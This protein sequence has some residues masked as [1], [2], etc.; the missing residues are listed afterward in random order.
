MEKQNKN[1]AFWM[2]CVILMGIFS[3]ISTYF[4]L[5][6]WQAKEQ[7]FKQENE[8]TNQEYSINLDPDAGILVEHLKSGQATQN[9]SNPADRQYL[10]EE[11][12]DILLETMP[13]FYYSPNVALVSPSSKAFQYPTIESEPINGFS[14]RENRHGKFL[15]QFDQP[16]T[17]WHDDQEFGWRYYKEGKDVPELHQSESTAKR[18]LSYS[19]LMHG[20]LPQPAKKYFFLTHTSDYQQHFDD[21]DIEYSILYKNPNSMVLT[22]P[23][24][25]LHSSIKALTSEF[26]EFP[27]DVT[28]EVTTVNGVWLH[29]YNGYE[30]L[31][32]VKK[33]SS[34]QDYVLTHYSERG[35]LDA[36]EE[37]LIEYSEYVSGTVGTSFVNNET[38]AQVSV[39]NQIFFPASTQKIYVLGELYHQYKTGELAPE[40]EVYLT[41]DNRVPGAGIIQGYPVGSPFTIDYLVD[42]VAIYSDNTAANTLIETVGGGERITPHMHQLG[43][44]DTYVDGKYYHSET[45][46]L[47]QTSPG[48]S[49]RFFALLYNN[50][51]NGEP[52]DEMLIEKFFMNTHNFLRWHVPEDTTAWNKSGLG[53]TEQNDVAT[54]VTPYGSYSLSAYT[55]EP[56]N[57]DSIGSELAQLSSAVMETF[58]QYRQKLWE[59]VEDPEAYMEELINN[60]S[61]AN[62]SENT[63]A[64]EETD[65]L[66]PEEEANN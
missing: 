49:A 61:L 20:L 51:V 59:T 29:V 14:W 32:W 45:N 26:V 12:N 46:G 8:T 57:Y 36:V 63:E 41:E 39:N 65:N 34:Y 6:N 42:L 13:W 28:E 33:D 30:E 21:Y 2:L 17:G 22:S 4:L 18:W 24:G 31:G 7:N 37:T 23:P 66:L 19:H 54:F 38:M 58:N 3:S 1:M 47:F 9:N 48:D 10:E 27:M 35:L 25:T 43:L 64:R 44:Y 15:F 52:W 16:Y 40:Q 56:W 55:E 50:R 11:D 60:N 5:M 53:G 62:E